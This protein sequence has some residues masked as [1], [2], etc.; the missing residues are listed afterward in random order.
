MYHTVLVLYMSPDSYRPV[1]LYPVCDSRSQY[2]TCPISEFILEERF[3]WEMISHT[4]IDWQLPG[5]PDFG[6][7][8]F[9][10]SLLSPFPLCLC[11]YDFLR[12]IVHS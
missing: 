7:S 2:C 5:L 8:S 9:P 6:P 12:D 11:L 4:H 3:I 1:V 10:F